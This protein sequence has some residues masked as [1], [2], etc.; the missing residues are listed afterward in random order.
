MKDILTIS[1]RAAARIDHLMSLRPSDAEPAVGIKI[2][3]KNAGC[4]GMS[5]T[6]DFA[7]EVPPAAEV[8]TQRGVTVVV[9]PAAVMFLIGTELDFSEDKLSAMFVFNNPNVTSTCG[10]GESFAVN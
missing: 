10:C 1:E 5:Y 7:E 8:I 6:M 4:S 3:V 2:G 9:D